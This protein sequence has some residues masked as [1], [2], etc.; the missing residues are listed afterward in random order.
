[1]G[2]VVPLSDEEM[3]NVREGLLDAGEPIPDVPSDPYP[4]HPD[5]P[6]PKEDEQ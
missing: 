3:N 5:D 2:I 4:L 1:M 6:Q